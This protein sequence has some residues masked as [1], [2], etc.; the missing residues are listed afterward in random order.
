MGPTGKFEITDGRTG[1]MLF[2]KLAEKRM[3]QVDEVVAAN[4]GAVEAVRRGQVSQQPPDLGVVI[5][6]RSSRLWPQRRR[7]KSRTTRTEGRSHMTLAVMESA[8]HRLLF[9]CCA[10]VQ[11]ETPAARFFFGHLLLLSSRSVN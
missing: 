9:F 5:V 1:A 6:F 7:K 8:I 2:S 4:R 3:P 10:P 11:V